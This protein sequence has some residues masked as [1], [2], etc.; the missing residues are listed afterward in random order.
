MAHCPQALVFR[1]IP[2]RWQLVFGLQVVVGEDVQIGVQRLRGVVVA[3]EVQAHG[4]DFGGA[5]MVAT[6]GAAQCVAR[7]L[8]GRQAEHGQAVQIGAFA[9]HLA[10]FL[11]GGIQQHQQGAWGGAW[12]VRFWDWHAGDH[13]FGWGEFAGEDQQRLPLRVGQQGQQA[14]GHFGARPGEGEGIGH[15]VGNQ[16][17]GVAGFERFDVA[18]QQAYPGAGGHAGA[19]AAQAVA[20]QQAAAGAARAFGAASGQKGFAA[21]RQALSAQ[22]GDGV[23]G[24]CCLLR[25]G[26]AGGQGLGVGHGVR[27]AALA[28]VWRCMAWLMARAGGVI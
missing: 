26:Q 25:C 5:E 8:L 1:P 9:E 20:G 21:A 23:G 24:S 15:D 3:G 16:P 28:R 10:R 4:G 7:Y 13:P 19:Q 11:P 12:L 14:G 6:F 17:A 2:L 22:A 27:R 18:H